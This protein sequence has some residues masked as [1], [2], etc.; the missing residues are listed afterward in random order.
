MSC[1]RLITTP[2]FGILLLCASPTYPFAQVT[3]GDSSATVLLQTY[4]GESEFLL[5]AANSITTLGTANGV[6]GDSS[7]NWL[8]TN[9]GTIAT[10]TSGSA[11][12]LKLDG[13]TMGASTIINYG[14]IEAHSS[15]GNGPAGIQFT[16]GGQVY[17]QA[18]GWIEGYDGVH[19]DHGSIL[20]ENRGT[21]HGNHGGG[22]AIYSGQGANITNFAGGLI[23]GVN[24]GISVNGF[25]TNVAILNYGMIQS[26]NQAIHLI[27]GNIYAVYNAP[28]ALIT[29][30]GGQTIL[31]E[32]SKGYLLNEGTIEA[33][34]TGLHSNN[35]LGENVY[36]NAGT[37][38]AANGYAIMTA[39]SDSGNTIYNM[40]VL[41]GTQGAVQIN[42]NNTLLVLG[43]TAFLPQLNR[44]V[45]GPGSQLG[46]DAISNG[47][48]NTVLLTDSGSEDNSLTGFVSLTMR[49]EE[50]TLEHALT[51]ADALLVDQ[52]RLNLADDLSVSNLGGGITVNSGGALSL[53]KTA[54]AETIL[55]DKGATLVFQA[56]NPGSSSQLPTDAFISADSINIQGRLTTEIND[57]TAFYLGTGTS[58]MVGN[59][60]Q[61]LT[62]GSDAEL[63][64]STPFYN[65]AFSRSGN[66]LLLSISRP[67]PL[68]AFAD[69]PNT[70]SLAGALRQAFSQG[71][72]VNGELRTALLDMVNSSQSREEATRRLSELSPAVIAGSTDLPPL[73]AKEF[74]ESLRNMF[75]EKRLQGTGKLAQS[76]RLAAPAAGEEG[77]VF[78]S[79]DSADLWHFRG[80]G[81][82]GW[83]EVNHNGS[84]P[85]YSATQWGGTGASW[86]DFGEA[87][88]G[89][90]AMGGHARL[91][92]DY[93]RGKTEG[94]SLAGALFVTFEHE[95]WLLAADALL[96][97]TH[98][99]SNREINSQNLTAEADYSA[100]WYG[101]DLYGGYR[102][103][104]ADWQIA[105]GVGA[106]WYRFNTPNV[107][108][109]G[110][111]TAGF[112]MD[113]DHRT[114]LEVLARLDVARVIALESV[115]LRPRAFVGVSIETADKLAEAPVHFID[116]PGLPTFTAYAPE[117]GRT[118]LNMG[119]GLDAQLSD[120]LVLFGE[121]QGELRE[122]AQTHGGRIGLEITF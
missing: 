119:L 86:R 26:A 42:G 78:A 99:D 104:A 94:N 82:G 109:N 103:L 54:S 108:E 41:S 89:F 47:Q 120:E 59:A 114:S 4:A 14:R 117:T 25:N 62:F 37:I 95:N 58:A 39:A 36:V 44:Y 111:G 21:I 118:A 88:L 75:W 70:R 56:Y 84:D 102:F 30:G 68:S 43:Q 74:R 121:Y 45:T 67:T 85:G 32:G 24:F 1:I 91:D 20:V 18:G 48:N 34:N 71:A 72:T 23:S 112:V 92:W 73:A 116:S 52:G 2:L 57:L 76:P 60:A 9:R 105:P 65:Y 15:S 28:N 19:T 87:S 113:A 16:N 77:G 83:S 12:G 79:A 27:N 107:E 115:T 98:I 122:D 55:V 50:W 13:S 33:D 63:L 66:D 61:T 17:N 6:E 11:S 5:P 101:V 106:R 64:G 22:T 10:D 46:G 100:Y 7:Q 96:G 90:A 53:Q 40:G 29:S 35:S 31:L 51:V 93:D 38:T 110:A 8:F 3:L 81:F 69:S 49:G 80:Q 97:A